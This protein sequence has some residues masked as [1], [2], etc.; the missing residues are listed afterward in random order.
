MAQLGGNLRMRSRLDDV[1][2]CTNGLGA[3]TR[4]CIRQEYFAQPFVPVLGGAETRQNYGTSQ[5]FE[6]EME[7]QC[8]G[9]SIR[10]Q[11]IRAMGLGDACTLC[12]ENGASHPPSSYGHLQRCAAIY[13]ALELEY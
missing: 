10:L 7:C 5:L 13:L 8:L 4:R 11:A 6:R 12:H 1:L 3:G 2:E 9:N